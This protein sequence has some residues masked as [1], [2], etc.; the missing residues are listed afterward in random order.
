MYH[1]SKLKQ[2]QQSNKDSKASRKLR[3]P[4]SDG[5]GESGRFTISF[6]RG[7]NLTVEGNEFIQRFRA[8][9]QKLGV[10]QNLGQDVI[11]VD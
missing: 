6:V 3:S 2:S 7:I 8:D 4:G 5:D 10:L 1:K 9:H 11:L